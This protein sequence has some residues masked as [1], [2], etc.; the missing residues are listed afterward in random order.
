MQCDGLRHSGTEESSEYASA[1][2][3]VI[4]V[5]TREFGLG[6]SLDVE[7][8][9]AHVMEECGDRERVARARLTRQRGALQGVLALGDR[10]AVVAIAERF[11]EFEQFI[12]AHRVTHARSS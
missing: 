9:V 10:F 7:R 1:A 6:L 3:F 11:V 12:D 8:E 2:R 4:V 5:V